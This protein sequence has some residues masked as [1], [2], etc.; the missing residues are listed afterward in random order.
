M[1]GLSRKRK[2]GFGVLPTRSVLLVC[3]SEDKEWS[4]RIAAN[5]RKYQ[6][7]IGVEVMAS[8]STLQVDVDYDVVVLAAPHGNTM[9]CGFWW[10]RT[11]PTSWG[12]IYGTHP[13]VRAKTRALLQRIESRA[14]VLVLCT[15]NQGLY[16]TAYRE[17]LGSN[18]G[19]VL[20]GWDYEILCNYPQCNTWI[21]R[22][23]RL[24]ALRVGSHLG[25]H[26]VINKK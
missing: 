22:G 19:L 6:I 18:S 13:K 7:N 12:L 15:C 2:Q 21:S 3:H 26:V 11:K 16:L 10:S 9:D 8:L 23:C 1:T 14:S 5:G 20:C 4:E 25:R 24:S 17:L